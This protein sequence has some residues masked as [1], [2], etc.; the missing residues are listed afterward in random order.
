[1]PCYL[2]TYHTHGS[3]L[4]DR[5]Q[6][7]VRKHEGILPQ[8]K[9]LANLYRIL[10]KQGEVSLADEIQLAVIET[11][12]G[13]APFLDCRVHSIATDDQHIHLL[14]SWRNAER[15]WMQTRSSFKKSVTLK[16]KSSHDAK[17]WLSRGAS[18]KQVNDRL[19]FDH[20]VNSYLPNHRGWKWD[21]RVG[22]YNTMEE[23]HQRLSDD[24]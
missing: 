3:W 24:A 15:E 22:Y 16:L 4:P 1:M 5:P 12:L 19:H 17:R 11:L 6:G 2:F 8:D 14:V 13:A 23:L 21:E 7:Y 18:R 10:M 20:L 9:Q